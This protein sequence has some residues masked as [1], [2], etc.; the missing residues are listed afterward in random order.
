MWFTPSTGVPEPHSADYQPDNPHYFKPP[1]QPCV[2]PLPRMFHF[3]LT[4][5]FIPFNLLIRPWSLRGCSLTHTILHTR[6]RHWQQVLVK[7]VTGGCRDWGNRVRR[8]SPWPTVGSGSVSQQTP[9]PRS[10]CCAA[11]PL[12]TLSTVTV[13][14]PTFCSCQVAPSLA[15]RGCLPKFS[16]YSSC[17]LQPRAWVNSFCS[18]SLNRYEINTTC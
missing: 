6:L 4:I 18:F 13:P 10:S 8:A 5:T 11:F 3:P 7:I 2:L 15:L 9:C 17:F 16:T 1:R 12:C 14:S